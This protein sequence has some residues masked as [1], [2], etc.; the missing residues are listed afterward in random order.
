M[1]T[2]KTNPNKTLL[3]HF[4]GQESYITTPKIYY[5]LTRCLNKAFVLNQIIFKT[6]TSTILK[7]DWFGQSYEDWEEETLL[8]ERTLRSYFK[9]FVGENWIEMRIR[10]INGTRTPIFRANLPNIEAALFKM[11]QGEHEP[12]TKQKAQN[13]PQTANSSELVKSCP[14]RQ[15]LPDGQT[16]K[17]AVSNTIYTY[18]LKKTTNCESSSSFLFSE[19]LDKNILDQKLDQDTRTNQEFLNQVKEHVD[20]HSDK[21]FARIQRA[22]GALRLLKKLK[23][24][25]IIFYVAGKEPKEIEK[26]PKE[27]ENQNKKVDYMAYVS[28]FKSDRDK[29]NLIPKNKEPLTFDEWSAQECQPKENVKASSLKLDLSTVLDQIA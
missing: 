25:N 15:N 1:S 10:K 29:L 20:H 9:E 6:G 28:Q 26:I 7:N 12:K 8:C 17:I 3:S 19:T 4:S 14:N 21:T 2:K 13:L 11:L 27:K 16:A 22:Q 5:K 18:D 24:Q 23:E